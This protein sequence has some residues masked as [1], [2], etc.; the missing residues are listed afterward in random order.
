MDYRNITVKESPS[1]TTDPT[2][3]APRNIMEIHKNDN[4]KQKRMHGNKQIRNA[5]DRK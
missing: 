4:A 2:D 1:G 3:D 5:S